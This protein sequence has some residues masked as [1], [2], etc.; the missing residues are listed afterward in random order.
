MQGRFKNC[1]AATNHSPWQKRFLIIGYL[2]YI[3]GMILFVSIDFNML[4]VAFF[5]YG[6]GKMLQLTS[7]QVLIG[8]IIPRNMRGTAN[9]CIQF[10]M[11]L[12]QGNLQVIV[13]FLYAFVSPHLPF[14]LLAAA[15]VP[16]AALVAVKVSEPA[17]KE[18]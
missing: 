15:A 7:F 11:Y 1:G 2:F 18:V 3:P 5:F 12:A 10:F 14:L 16:F 13:G 4:L 17:V 6:L 8:D 9:D